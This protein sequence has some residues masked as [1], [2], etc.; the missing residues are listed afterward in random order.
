MYDWLEHLA[1]QPH[2]FGALG[3]AEAVLFLWKEHFEAHPLYEQVTTLLFHSGSKQQGWFPTASHQLPLTEDL[4]GFHISSSDSPGRMA[5]GLHSPGIIEVNTQA[6]VCISNTL[7]LEGRDGEGEAP[8]AHTR[9]REACNEI[10]DLINTQTSLIDAY[11]RTSPLTQL[12]RV[13]K[14]HKLA[15][16]CGIMAQII[17][18]EQY[19]LDEPREKRC[20]D[21]TLLRF[22]LQRLLST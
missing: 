14:L 6:V 20:E 17:K 21:L 3:V 18:S 5:T 22:Y 12:S 8:L 10:A 9:Y 16:Q 19:C 4:S 2:T 7:A 1:G 13:L 15:T 11:V